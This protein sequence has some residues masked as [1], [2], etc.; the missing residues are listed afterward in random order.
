[1]TDTPGSVP[2][3]LLEREVL[4]AILEALLKFPEP[5]L[6]VPPTRGV[7][8]QPCQFFKDLAGSR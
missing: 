8:N 2:T 4:I 5:L 3:G 6:D 1:M 7:V